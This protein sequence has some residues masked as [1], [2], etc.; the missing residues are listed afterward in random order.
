MYSFIHMKERKWCCLLETSVE[1]QSWEYE[2]FLWGHL[3]DLIVCVYSLL[4]HDIIFKEL[5]CNILMIFF[6]PSFILSPPLTSEH[7]VELSRWAWLN[8]FCST[9][10]MKPSICVTQSQYM[11]LQTWV[12]CCGINRAYKLH[13]RVLLYSV[14]FHRPTQSIKKQNGNT[15]R[16]ALVLIR[17]LGLCFWKN[18]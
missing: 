18:N 5:K 12:L 8:S 17:S 11:L 13:H 10:Y 4:L 15:K 16:V 1:H 9:R 14:V 6:P 3:D 7:S 2:S